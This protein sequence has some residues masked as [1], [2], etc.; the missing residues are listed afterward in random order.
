MTREFRTSSHRYLVSLTVLKFTMASTKPNTHRLQKIGHF[1]VAFC[2]SGK[3]I[4]RA[5][6]PY[7]NVHTYMFMFAHFHANQ[8]HFEFHIRGFARRLVLKKR[9]K[10]SETAYYLII[11]SILLRTRRRWGSIVPCTVTDLP[12][13]SYN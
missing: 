1:R 2:L 11:I 7:G 6:Y 13:V 9:R 8:N 12:N 4:L 10:N 5:T 3:T